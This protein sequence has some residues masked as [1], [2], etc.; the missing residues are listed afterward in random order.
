MRILSIDGGGIRGII[1]GTILVAFEKRL[2]ELSGDKTKRIADVFDLVAGTSTGGILSCL[3]LCPD[4]KHPGRP[5]FTAEE[6]VNLYLQNGDD[7]FDISVFK[8]LSSL[9][10]LADERYSAECLEELLQ[11]YFDELKLSDLLK[12]CLI[13]AYDI[14]RRQAH[15]FNKA[16]TRGHRNEKDFYVRDVARS[17]SAA[18]TYFEPSKIMA[19]DRSVYPLID[20][21]VF[22]NNP[23]MCACVEAFEM[24]HELRLDD[25]KILSIGTGTTVKPYHYSEVKNWGKVAWIS[26]IL[27]IM[28][29][30]VSETVDFQMKSLFRCAGCAGQYLRLEVDLGEFPDVDGAMDNASETNMDA[31]QRAAEKFAKRDEISAKLDAFAKLLLNG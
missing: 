18:P 3:Y 5:R 29:S 19:M 12:P 13:T 20:G 30:G 27:N 26:P 23:T 14:T 7:V 11:S 8:E 2:Q 28:M 21:G 4:K 6:A 1:P 25:L 15:F 16:D 22:A 31:L 17:T 9:G 24:N 10:G